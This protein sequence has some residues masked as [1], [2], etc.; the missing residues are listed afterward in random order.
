MSDEKTI[1]NINKDTDF[2]VKV[3]NNP[4]P[5][6]SDDVNVFDLGRKESAKRKKL[7]KHKGWMESVQHEFPL[8]S[9]SFRIGIYIRYFNQTNHEDYLEQHKKKFASDIALCPNW[10]L[11]DFYIDYGMSAPRM[12]NSPEW[13][14]LLGDCFSGKVNLIVTQLV[15]NVSG[16]PDEI[17]L[18]AR[19]LAAQKEPVGIYFI[20]E[21]IFT[22][23]SYYRQDL[24]DESFLPPD[25][26]TLP[27]DELDLP[28][29][30][31]DRKMI[32][33]GSGD[34]KDPERGISNAYE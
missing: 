20:S 8:P 24:K 18:I 5:V 22:L 19:L 4:A 32:G 9:V 11:V 26:K 13:C 27:D 28:L 23:A 33:A 3:Q 31:P 7:L 21:N 10:T 12:E 16:D 34:D 14:R 2:P 1:T 17:G 15:R 6:I 30:G 25:W 29:T